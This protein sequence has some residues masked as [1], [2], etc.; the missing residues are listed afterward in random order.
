[1]NENFSIFVLDDSRNL[2]SRVEHLLVNYFV[3]HEVTNRNSIPD[4]QRPVGLMKYLIFH[5]VSQTVYLYRMFFFYALEL[6]KL[7][8]RYCIP[9][10]RV[11]FPILMKCVHE[12]E[13]RRVETVF[14]VSTTPV[15]L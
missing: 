10:S 4:L 8:I 9:R 13:L 2:V 12:N 5:F 1:M 7:L 3:L 11:L 6:N 14:R 15:N